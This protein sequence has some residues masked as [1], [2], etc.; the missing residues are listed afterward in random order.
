MLLSVVMAALVAGQSPQDQFFDRLSA[1]CGQRF[2]GRLASAPT[3][4]DAPFQQRLVVEV[5]DCQADEIRMPLTV[6]EDRSRTWIV[7]RTAAGL[8]LKHDHRHPD[9]SEDRLTQYGGDTAAPG[10]AERQAFPADS[11]SKDLFRRE[12]AAVSV[13]NVWALEI[14]PSSD[15]VYELS[16]PDRLFRLAFDLKQPL[17]ARTGK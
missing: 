5:R 13:S 3:A 6:G 17:D 9:G 14:R 16:R 10:T 1:L 4:A 11:Y 7:T 15:L 2:E 12:N 8:R